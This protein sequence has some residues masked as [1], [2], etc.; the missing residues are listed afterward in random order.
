MEFYQTE[1]TLSKRIKIKQS[2]HFISSGEAMM[3]SFRMLQGHA[4]T[5]F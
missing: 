2:F 3:R 5:G 4:L 1:H